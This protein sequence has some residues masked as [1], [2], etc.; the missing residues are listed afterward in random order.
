MNNWLLFTIAAPILWAVTNVMDGALRKHFV[1]SNFALTWIFA[2]ARL[3]FVILFFIIAGIEI[4]SPIT[5]IMVFIGGVF[6]TLP[7][8]FYFRALETE[9]PSRVALVMQMLPIFTLL[10]AYFALGE[11]LTGMQGVAFIFLVAGGAFAALK[12][13]EGKWRWSF[14]ALLVMMAALLWATSDVVFKKYEVE[15]TNFL[16]AFAIYF[17]GSFFFS[18]VSM[19]HPEG[20]KKVTTY[21]KNLP[22]R[23]WIMIT[24]SLLTG[25]GGSVSFAYALTLGKASLTSVIIGTQPLIVVLLGIILAGTTKEIQRERLNKNEV[26]LKGTSFILILIGLILLSV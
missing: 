23:A 26:F 9:E 14:A 16:S 18:L 15:F 5:A 21:F 4:P 22:L 3:P 25:I 11:R 6:W 13:L 1:K 10:I 2:L 12:K 20:R 17:L 7:M 19:A 8:M 24:A